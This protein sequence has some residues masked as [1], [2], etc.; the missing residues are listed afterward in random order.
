[1][2]PC[3]IATVLTDVVII[4]SMINHVHK[5]LN[6]MLMENGY[7]QS[8]VFAEVVVACFK[9]SLIDKDTSFACVALSDDRCKLRY[10]AG[11]FLLEVFGHS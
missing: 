8:D 10:D 2:S 7:A 6:N 11:N 3:N 5:C 9:A 1:M 4:G